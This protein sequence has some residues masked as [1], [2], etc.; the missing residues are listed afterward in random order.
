MNPAWKKWVWAM[1]VAGVVTVIAIY[2]VQAMAPL[3]LPLIRPAG[4]FQL[5]NQLKAVVTQAD[6]AGH[7]TVV[8]VVFSRCPTQ[9]HRL[10]QKMSQLQSQIPNG[11]RLVSLTADPDYDQ[12]DVL[13][14]YAKRYGGDASLWW[15]LTGPKS[16]IYSYAT[17]DLLFTVLENPNPTPAKLEDMFIHSSDFA[18]L[19]RQSRLRAVV[20]GEDDDAVKQIV[21]LV[22][23]LNSD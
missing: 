19:D 2:V 3:P 11:T 15:L 5:T 17:R 10:S 20:H 21:R 4:R 18:I 6:I 7:V 12:P 23:R 8:N 13:A 1:L 16:E 14:T 9:C 22:R